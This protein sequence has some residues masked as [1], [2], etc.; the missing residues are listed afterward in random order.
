MKKVLIAVLILL[1]ATA[2]FLLKS[3]N[4]SRDRLEWSDLSSEGMIWYDAVDYCKNLKEGGHSDW[5]LP[6]I[7]ELRTLIQNNPET[8]TGGKCEISEKDGNLENTDGNCGPGE[9]GYNFSTLGDTKTLWSMSTSKETW[10]MPWVIDFSKGSMFVEHITEN[11]Y[12][13][14]CVRQE[15]HDMCETARNYERFYYWDFYFNKFPKGECAEEA[16]AFIEKEDKEVCEEARK[17][18]TRASW[19]PYLKIFPKGK[20]AEEGNA[21]R[22]KYKKI[23][24]LEWSDISDKALNPDNTFSYCYN[25]KEGG[26]SDWRL[27][28]IDELRTLVQNHPDTVA[29]GKCNISENGNIYIVNRSSSC[30]GIEGKDFS[31]LGDTKLLLSSTYAYISYDNPGLYSAGSAVWGIDF[32]Y[33]EIVECQYG[34]YY[35]RCVR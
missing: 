26:H 10:W 32:S 34:L 5:R 19:E 2:L 33:G 1:I 3:T 31:K 11:E 25:L 16:K 14:R 20:C 8:V 15:E 13:V 29:G 24:G 22:N 6:N 17:E 35:F 9:T 12:S 27:P 7:D 28:N 30:D 18:N 23:D 21:V 4:K